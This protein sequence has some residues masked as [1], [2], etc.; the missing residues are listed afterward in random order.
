MY[1]KCNSGS[2]LVLNNNVE[3][4]VTTGGNICLYPINVVTIKAISIGIDGD[5]SFKNNNMESLNN[6][7][8]K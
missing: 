4:F 3:F 8:Y 6:G 7:I 1:I 5:I 2:F